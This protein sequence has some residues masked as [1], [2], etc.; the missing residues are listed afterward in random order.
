MVIRPSD[1]WE[2]IS[3]K[4]ESCLA[5]ICSWMSANKLKL[6][7]DKTE[8]IVFS[9]KQ[10]PESRQA[11]TLKVGACTVKAASAV[12]N[13]GVFFDSSLT[14]EKQVNAV[15]KFVITRYATLVAF[16]SILP[17]TPAKPL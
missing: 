3:T 11:F 8:L 4:L 2:N 7:Q 16:A 10:N 13:L 1:S 15:S 17:L 12:K 5:D 14:M 6:I 9:S